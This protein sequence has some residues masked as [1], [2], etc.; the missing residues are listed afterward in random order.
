MNQIIMAEEFRNAIGL[1]DLDV[2]VC[3]CV[4]L[5]LVKVGQQYFVDDY[6]CGSQLVF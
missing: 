5:F 2:C 4:C 3:L 1:L 6:S